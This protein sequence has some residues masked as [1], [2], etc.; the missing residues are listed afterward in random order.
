MTKHPFTLVVSNQSIK[1]S[2]VDIEVRVDGELVVSEE[3]EVGGGVREQ[4]Q[5]RELAFELEGGSHRIEVS[6][7]R[8][9]AA[10]EDAFELDGPKWAALAFW[11]P[12]GRSSGEQKE[13][14]FTLELSDRPIGFY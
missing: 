14:L 5:W 13:A 12:A 6:S 2:P 7:Q 3:F 10:L 4:H 8:G 11:S 1:V 9:D